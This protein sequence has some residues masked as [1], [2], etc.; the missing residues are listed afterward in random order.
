MGKDGAPFPLNP[1]FKPPI[2][3]SNAI[4][5]TIYE[6]FMCAT[7]PKVAFR[8][9][10]SKYHLS[11]ARLDAILR[12]KGLEKHMPKEQLQTGFLAGMERILG[13]P[14]DASSRTRYPFE[15]YPEIRDEEHADMLAADAQD[16]AETDDMKR[17][18][19][20]YQRQFWEAVPEDQLEPQM[21]VALEKARS[22]AARWELRRESQ[23]DEIAHTAS[24]A[25]EKR[26]DLVIRSGKAANRPLIRFKD[27]G[28][29]LLDVKEEE[30]RQRQIE[31]RSKIHAR[32]REDQERRRATKHN[33]ASGSGHAS[34]SI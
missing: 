32:S 34:Y 20:R 26:K 19:L 2:P 5:N 1:T 28:S 15:G 21:P 29:K 17:A 14:H 25:R 6:E 7:D 23:R 16:E 22:D 10:A 24:Q 8:E 9:I 30:K 11:L 27:V 4:R 12:L 18:R 13:V 3:I 31:R 33:L